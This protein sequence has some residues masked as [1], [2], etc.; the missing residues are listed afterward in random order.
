MELALFQMGRAKATKMFLNGLLLS[1]EDA[2]EFG[3]VDEICPVEEVLARAEA[4]LDEWLTLPREPWLRAKAALRKPLIEAMEMEFLEA[5][6][7]TIH[8]WWSTESR[9][10]FGKMVEKLKSSE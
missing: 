8:G 6:G 4:K 2:K 3:L 9:T 1:P 7:E 10:M 5:F